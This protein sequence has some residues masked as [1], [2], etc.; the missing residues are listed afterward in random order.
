MVACGSTGKRFGR[1]LRTVRLSN[2]RRVP[3][4]ASSS[5]VIL[6]CT[7]DVGPDVG[8]LESIDGDA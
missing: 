7:F 4:L 2:I 1:N 6:Y 5:R 3:F 8:R